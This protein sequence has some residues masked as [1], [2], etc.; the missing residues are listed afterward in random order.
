LEDASGIYTPKQ[1]ADKVNQ[2]YEKWQADVVVAERNHGGDLVKENIS[3]NHPHIYVSEVVA[4]RGKYTRAEP[5]A[6]LY[7]RGLIHHTGNFE[8]LC[9]E[10]IEFKPDDKKQKSPDRLDSVVW[11]IWNLATESQ[12]LT[13]L[14]TMKSFGI[15]SNSGRANVAIYGMR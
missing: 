10:M 15:V 7:E 8:D 5:V 3:R 9:N 4:T 6:A 2:L 1:W 11:A 14:S 13:T 12:G